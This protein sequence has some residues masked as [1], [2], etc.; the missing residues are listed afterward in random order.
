MSRLKKFGLSLA[1]SALLVVAYFI[2]TD[3]SFLLSPLA[4]IGEKPNIAAI[5]EGECEIKGKTELCKINGKVRERNLT[6]AEHAA[7]KGTYTCP[8]NDGGVCISEDESCDGS[9]GL[10]NST[11]TCPNKTICCAKRAARVVETDDDT[12]TTPSKCT[13]AKL[14]E[15]KK[16]QTVCNPDTGLCYDARNAPPASLCTT[17]K[18]A[19][20]KKTQTV[21]NPDTGLCYDARNAPPVVTT[22]TTQAPSSENSNIAQISTGAAV[23]CA[24]GGSAGTLVLPVI[25]TAA[26]CVG[27][28][29]VGALVGNTVGNALES[30]NDAVV[31]TA[32]VTGGLVATVPNS[33]AGQAGATAVTGGQVANIPNSP[34]AQDG[35]TAVAGGL[36]AP[37]PVVEQ[38][39]AD[40]VT[41]QTAPAAS[42]KTPQAPPVHSNISRVAGA[43]IGILVSSVPCSIAGP[44][45]IP[46]VAGSATL[47]AFI[48]NA[49]G[50]TIYD[51]TH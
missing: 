5:S 3:N 24:A 46:C 8:K 41:T 7:S 34:A 25:G 26:G 6:P 1:A 30:E 48:G 35:A 2:F 12:P 11:G 20:C 36:L 17:A 16:T 14:A 37:A 4:W 31:A 43:S 9:K 44:L 38:D 39:E 51:I 18:L 32:A 40:V 21:C 23:G 13:T 19:E 22:N 28:A 49:V 15:C 33:P 29:V 50:N 10:V 27:G 45:Y 47:G 42:T